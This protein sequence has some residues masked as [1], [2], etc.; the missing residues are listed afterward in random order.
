MFA[1]KKT[2]NLSFYGRYVLFTAF[3]YT[4]NII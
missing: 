2:D 3:L 1:F 4:K